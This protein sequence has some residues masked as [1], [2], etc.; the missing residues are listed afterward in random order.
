LSAGFPEDFIRPLSRGDV[1]RYPA[2]FPLRSLF[3]SIALRHDPV[4]YL[5]GFRGIA[6]AYF[7]A[8]NFSSYII[9]P[10]NEG[11]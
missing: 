10:G 11:L 4:L 9:R 5:K 8:R 7:A 1:P 3:S 6:K 2:G